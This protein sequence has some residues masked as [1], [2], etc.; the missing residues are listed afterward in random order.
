M[1][2]IEKKYNGLPDNAKEIVDLI[3]KNYST[4]VPQ[5]RLIEE[6]KNKDVDVTYTNP[7]VFYFCGKEYE[8]SQWNNLCLDLVEAIYSLKPKKIIELANKKWHYSESREG[9]RP[10]ITNYCR[11]P[12]DEKIYEKLKNADK[13]IYVCVNNSANV[14]L[15]FAYALIKECG[16]EQED[17]KI[18]IK[19]KKVN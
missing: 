3:F 4:F 16:Y 11:F 14:S 2:I 6:V 18:L 10:S 12:N 5:E 9:K 13:Q 15:Q 19:N 7:V 8:V 17:L 1:G